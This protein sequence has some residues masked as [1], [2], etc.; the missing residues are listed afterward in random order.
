MHRSLFTT[1]C[2]ALLI[3]G[4]GVNAANASGAL[5]ATFDTDGKVTTR[6]GTNT[7]VAYAMALQSDN[8]IVLGGYSYIGSNDDFSLTRYNPDGS[9]DTSFDT[10]GKVTTAVGSNN[11]AIRDVAI[12]SDGKILAVGYQYDGSQYD[13]ALVRYNSDGSLDTSFDTDGKVTTAIGSANNSSFSVAIQSDGKIVAGGFANNGFNDDFALTRYN[14]DGSL[15][16]SFDTDGKVTTQ[17]GSYSEVIRSLAIQS[18]GKIVAVG[19]SYNGSNYDFAIARYNSNGSLDNSFNTTGKVTTAIGTG[20]EYAM[21]SAIQSDGKIV[22]VG[23]SH[24]GSDNDFALV[25]YNSDGSLDSSFNTSGKVTTSIGPASNSAF[26]VAVLND[27]KIVV[28]G[29]ASNGSNDDFALARYNGD[30]LLDASFGTDGKF[31]TDFGSGNDV[32]YSLAVQGDGK[33]VASGYAY[34][35]I[36]LDFATI[37][38]GITAAAQPNDSEAAAR[39]AAA[40]REAERRAARAE[41]LDKFKKSEAVSIETFSLADIAG[42][43]K[44]NI[45][46]VQEEISA[47]P[48]TSRE[49]LIPILQIARKYEVVGTIA[50]DRVF[51][52]YS[53]NLIEIGL[54]PADNKHKESLTRAV[55]KLPVSDRSSFA[56]IKKA[57]DAEIAK[58]QARKDRLAAAIARRTSS[59]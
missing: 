56:A 19:Y 24:N 20:D 54:I 4:T 3:S 45:D 8:K 40:R 22:A 39:E 18:D 7:D 41:I 31:T 26:S 21:S 16:T 33:L 30:G 6:V 37:K 12:Q 55:K 14:S 52:V 46:A 44:E 9:L 49:N 59:S 27:G 51:S 23:Y 15:D 34:N 47:I 58:I 35:G 17:I 38:Y 36:N 32:A 10:D 48:E 28:A 50:S 43:T 29:F 5:D 13:F 42:I 11:E 57:L 2:A 53:S 1:F 25:R